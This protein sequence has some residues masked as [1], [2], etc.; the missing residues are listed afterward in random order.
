MDIVDHGRYDYSAIH[1]RPDYDWPEGKRL[2]FYV[3]LNIEH[4]SFGE[5]LGHTPTFT[6]PAPDARNYAW[7]DYGLR[8]GV[9]RILDILEECGLPACHLMNTAVYDYAP[10]IAHAV[11]NRGDEVVGH[12]HTNSER[13]T[14]MTLEQEWDMLERVT[15]R[16]TEEEGKPPGGWLSPWIAENTRTPDLV[17]KAGYRYLLDWPCDDQPV[18]F[19]T[20]HGPLLSIPYPVELNDT[21]AM[22][23]RRHTMPEFSAM[24]LDQFEEM[25]WQSQKQPLVCGLSLHTPAVGHPFRLRHLRDLLT[26][27]TRHPQRDRVWF[28]TPGAIASHVAAL[29]EGI[30]PGG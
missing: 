11:R 4:F 23:V 17:R 30:V 21:P 29:P 14:E 3:A 26:R 5:T 6:L 2:A 15:R 28:T 12:G 1:R 18:W 24:V 16:L 19:R 7:R 22:M 25:L 13:Q 9:W 20:E 27:I 10:D 8:V